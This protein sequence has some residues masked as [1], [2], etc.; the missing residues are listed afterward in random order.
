MQNYFYNKTEEFILKTNRIK[1]GS[2][3]VNLFLEARGKG[4]MPLP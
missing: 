3:K 2:P 1:L 4:F